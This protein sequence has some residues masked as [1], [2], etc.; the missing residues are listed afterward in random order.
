VGGLLLRPKQALYRH[1]KSPGTLNMPADEAARP[2][3]PLDHLLNVIVRPH[4]A[5]I[6][7]VVFIYQPR[8]RRERGYARGSMMKDDRAWHGL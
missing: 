1:V 7:L 2:T 3:Y 8:L 4:A 5:L 6:S